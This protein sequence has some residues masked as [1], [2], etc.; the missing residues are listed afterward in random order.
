[1]LWYLLVAIVNIFSF[2]LDSIL[3]NDDQ[4]LAHDQPGN[5][6]IHT[7]FPPKPRE[8]P[9]T[10]T[11][12]HTYL[13]ILTHLSTHIHTISSSHSQTPPLSTHYILFRNTHYMCITHTHSHPHTH[14]RRPPTLLTHTH[15]WLPTH[16]HSH[17]HPILLRGR[18]ESWLV[19]MYRFVHA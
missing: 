4:R 17:T 6:N 7:L 11:H 19:P 2:I 9:H 3:Q 18:A 14:P 1:M 16:T 10:L 15:T 8:C 13:H 5:N 12:T